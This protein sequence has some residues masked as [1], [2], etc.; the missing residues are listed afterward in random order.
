MAQWQHPQMDEAAV[1]L[2]NLP[3]SWELA[4]RIVLAGLLAALL[5]LERE[6][7]DHPSG[8]RTHVS[9]AIGAALFGICS[10]YAFTEFI[11]LR[12]DNNYQVDVTRIAA[13]IVSGVGFLG[14]GAIIKQGNTVRGLTSAAGLWVSAAIGLAVSLGMYIEATVSTLA[15]LAALVLLKP[16]RRWVRSRVRVTRC[17]VS[18]Q[19]AERGRVEPVIAAIRALDDIDIEHL[20][21]HAYRDDE[22]EGQTVVIRADL[23][24][25]NGAPENRLAGVE[26]LEGVLDLEIN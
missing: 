2:P 18:I 7:S 8:L 5:G 20:E 13:Q 22:D 14:G 21:T 24:V 11:A 23:A 6:F 9:V 26:S 16:L 10:A 19:V 17:T 15:L 25:R 3:S 12:A 1:V 4:G